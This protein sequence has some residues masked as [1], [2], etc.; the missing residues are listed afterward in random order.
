MDSDIFYAHFSTGNCELMM[1]VR[2]I[3]LHQKEKDGGNEFV[4]T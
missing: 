3:K 1:F 2:D 4:L